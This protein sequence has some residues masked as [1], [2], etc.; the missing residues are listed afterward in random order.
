M[1]KNAR[2]MLS[3]ALKSLGPAYSDVI[4]AIS[5]KP[6]IWNKRTAEWTQADIDKAKENASIAIRNRL[7]FDK[8]YDIM[9]QFNSF[10]SEHSHGLT[11]TPILFEKLTERAEVEMEILKLTQGGTDPNLNKRTRL[12]LAAKLHFTE[13]A[14]KPYLQRLK[15]ENKRNLLGSSVGIKLKHGENIYDSTIHPVFLALNLSEVNFLVNHLRLQ[16][17]GTQHEQI[18]EMI[19][20]DVYR[21]LSDYAMDRMDAVAA[22]NDIRLGSSSSGQPLHAG[23]HSETELK[24]PNL[25]RVIKMGGCR[26]HPIDK[27]DETHIGRIRWHEDGYLFCGEDGFSLELNE[28]ILGEYEFEFLNESEMGS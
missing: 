18:A 20:Y 25:D 26:I 24:G 22:I 3:T 21:Q 9:V 13:D 10:M 23:Y 6:E 19:S 7:P 14:L 15:K 2:E 4:A 28:R 17:K 5:K 8:R 12:D 1:V 16:F 11:Y 27:P